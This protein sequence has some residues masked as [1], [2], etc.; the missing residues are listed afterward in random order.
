MTGTTVYKLQTSPPYFSP[1]HIVTAIKSNS[2]D[3]DNLQSF[4]DEYALR[5]DHPYSAR[6]LH[7]SP[8][9]HRGRLVWPMDHHPHNPLPFYSRVHSHTT[10]SPSR[11]PRKLHSRL[12]HRGSEVDSVP[13]HLSNCPCCESK[14]ALSTG[15]PEFQPLNGSSIDKRM[16]RSQA[17]LTR[18]CTGLAQS[19]LIGGTERGRIMGKICIHSLTGIIPLT[20]KPHLMTFNFWPTWSL[21]CRTQSWC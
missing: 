7:C 13:P 14:K 17:L 16:L 12:D 11:R 19:D 21:P 1:T 8:T 9:C 3:S 2:G 10:T 5:R 6:A 18:K 15:S 4:D 20:T